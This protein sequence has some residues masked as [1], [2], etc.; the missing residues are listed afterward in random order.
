MGGK[1]YCGR[2]L[3]VLFFSWNIVGGFYKSSFLVGYILQKSQ[4]TCP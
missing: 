3:Q 1:E 2:F 4:D